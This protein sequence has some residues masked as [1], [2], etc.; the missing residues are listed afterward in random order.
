MGLPQ[1]R[2]PLMTVFELE[3]E[4]VSEVP[5]GHVVSIKNTGEVTVER[6]ADEKPK[7]P[8]SFERIYFSRGNDPEIYKERKELGRL[9][10]DPILKSIDHNLSD[11]VFSFIP[12]TADVAYHGMMGG[13]GNIAETKL[14]KQLRKPLLTVVLMRK[15]LMI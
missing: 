12:N 6:F 10:A 14:K 13:L 5:A 3:K 7:T 11:T 8:C 15:R 2:V 1:K 4:E 9:L